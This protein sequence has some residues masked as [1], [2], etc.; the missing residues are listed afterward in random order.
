MIEIFPVQGIHATLQV[1]G[2]KYVANRVLLMAALA[3][4]ISQIHNAPE[5]NDIAHL[6]DVLAYLGVAVQKKKKNALFLKGCGGTVVAPLQPLNVGESGTL[7]RFITSIASLCASPVT[8]TGSRRI[9]ER[10]IADLLS[11]LEN[12]GVKI[13]ST[14]KGYAPLSINGP[15]VGGT[16]TIRG[17][18]SSQF[19]SSLLLAVPYAQKNTTIKLSGNAVSKKYIDMTI[20]LM[21]EFGVN[22][23]RNGYRSFTVPSSQKYSARE[24][25]ISGDWSSANYFFAAAAI[26]RGSVT[27]TGL[28]LK[29]MQG[30]SEFVDVLHKMGCRVDK[31]NERVTVCSTEKLSGIICDMEQLPDAV[32]TLAVV[33]CYA[34]GKTHIKNI[35]HLRYKESDRISETARE[36]K[37]LGAAVVVKKDEMIITPP[38]KLTPAIIDPHN[39]HRLAM[40]FA[41]AGLTVK[42]IK[43]KNESCVNKSFPQFWEY[44]KKSGVEVKYA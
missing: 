27:V 10:P 16:A 24:Y 22:V 41:L 38:L 12:L 5:N 25:T 39:D 17:E 4:G 6:I 42:G 28:D 34:G 32:P 37:K 40:S 7:F 30:E 23:L 26:A 33:A 1:P 36:L 20:G 18:I 11:G 3:D 43:I 2:S 21:K 15:L 44:L 8:I 29:S 13:I 14:N 31:N 35:G 9:G 19:V